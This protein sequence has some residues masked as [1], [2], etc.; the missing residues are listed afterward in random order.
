MATPGS[1]D[2]STVIALS[3]ATDNIPYD[4]SE[5]QEELTNQES[6]CN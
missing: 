6:C 5:Q 1:L 3:R 2:P 4:C